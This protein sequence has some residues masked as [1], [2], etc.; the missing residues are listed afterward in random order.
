M[1]TVSLKLPDP[2][3]LRLAQT[4]RHRSMSKSAV[5]RD[6]LEAY[7]SG[8]ETHPHGS[9]LSLA[10]DVQGMLSGP[11]DLSSNKNYLRNFGR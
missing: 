8:I 1:T 11:E 9:A 5:I 7:L 2:L 10:G 3:A 6:A 4:A